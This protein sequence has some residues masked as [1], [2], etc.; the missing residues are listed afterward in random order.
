MT[1]DGNGEKAHANGL[2]PELTAQVLPVLE[3]YLMDLECG[4][5]PRPG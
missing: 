3:N 1:A 5:R 4:R 2:P